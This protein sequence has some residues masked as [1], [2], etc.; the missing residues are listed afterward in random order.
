[1]N[2]SSFVTDS[3]KLTYVLGGAI[4]FMV[5][6]A[7]IFILRNVG[8]QQTGGDVTLKVW[9]VFDDRAVFSAAFKAFETANKGVHIDYQVFPPQEYEAAVINALAAGRG[10]DVW[11][12]HHTWLPKHIDKIQPMP[13]RLTGDKE[14]LMT[15]KQFK[16]LFVDVAAYDLVNNGKIYGLPLYVDTLALYYNKDMFSS[17]GIAQPPRTWNDF[18]DDVKKITQY[19]ANRNI[20]RLGAAMGS[21]RNIN[22]STDILM[23]LML[24]SGVQ[25]TNADGTQATFSRSVDGQNVG[26]RALMFYTDFTNPQKEVYTWNDAMDYSIDAFAEGS[27]AMMIN[28]AHQVSVIRSKAPRLNWAVAAVPQASTVDART[29]ANYWPLVVSLKSEHPETAWRLVHYLAAGE[30]T[31]PYLNAA[32]RP[33][34]RRDLI[35]QQ[36]SD[37][38]LGVFALQALTA[39]SWLQANNQTIETIF[40]DMIDAVNLGRQSITNALRDA[41]TKVSVLMSGR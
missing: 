17:A 10:P 27:T 6:I 29:Y 24:Q 35:E 14:P 22:R 4:A 16:D 3:R 23:M 38:D 12:M 11:M 36:K 19:D 25:M 34:A 7:F 28:Y 26:E 21:A 39:R 9:G 18:M 37:P 5:F 33:S 41:E 30:G 31:V 40:A 2:I 1:M 20:T 32:N 13:E 8:G 15:I